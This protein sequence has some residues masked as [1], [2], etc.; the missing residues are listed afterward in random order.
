MNLSF[1]HIGQIHNLSNAPNLTVLNIHDNKLTDL[2][3]KVLDLRNLKTLKMTNNN[4]STINLKIGLMQELLW[5]IKGN[6]LSSLKPALRNAAAIELKKY[7]KARLTVEEIEQEE[8]KA[9]SDN[10]TYLKKDRVNDDSY[11]LLLKTYI[12]GMTQDLRKE[13]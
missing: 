8:T 4:L 6:P 11:D 12:H 10:L 2:P 13:S 7:L 1:N 3:D 5:S 9:K